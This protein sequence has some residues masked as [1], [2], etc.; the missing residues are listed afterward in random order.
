MRELDKIFSL[1]DD[2]SALFF[3]ILIGL[4]GVDSKG[5]LEGPRGPGVSKSQLGNLRRL[6]RCGCPRRSMRSS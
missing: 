1:Q 6:K 4:G 3:K 5:C 2:S